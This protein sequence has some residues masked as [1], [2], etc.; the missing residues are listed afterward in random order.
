MK[1]SGRPAAVFRPEIINQL[2]V[3][4]I[5][6]HF[7]RQ[8]RLSNGNKE[9][10]CSGCDR[11]A[12]PERELAF[13]VR[14]RLY[15]GKRMIWQI[16]L[17]HAGGDAV[18]TDQQIR[19]S[20]LA[21]FL[22]VLRK[23]QPALG[24]GQWV[25]LQGQSEKNYGMKEDCPNQTQSQRGPCHPAPYWVPRKYL[26]PKDHNHYNS[27][28]QGRSDPVGFSFAVEAEDEIHDLDR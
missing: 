1:M 27:G 11:I 24:P 25:I 16:E 5:A 2:R 18:V 17:H 7:L 4:E 9:C 6:L 26:P 12:R 21:S 20:L 13:A 15:V 3:V 14:F 10:P 23:I 22:Y 19:I 8:S 28:D